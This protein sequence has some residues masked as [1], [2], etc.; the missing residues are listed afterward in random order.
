MSE[1]SD[2]HSVEQ[3]TKTPAMA[4]D[5]CIVHTCLQQPK[6][7]ISNVT[8]CTI[9]AKRENRRRKRE[10]LTEIPLIQSQQQTK[11]PRP[12]F[13][14]LIDESV[15]DVEQCCVRVRP[16]QPLC[17]QRVVFKI[18]NRYFCRL[19][20]H[21]HPEAKDA[22]VLKPKVEEPPPFEDLIDQKQTDPSRC[23]MREGRNRV[24]CYK[25]VTYKIRGKYFCG[26]HGTK[27]PHGQEAIT[28]PTT[29]HGRHAVVLNTM[30]E[31][32]SEITIVV[33][34]LESQ[35]DYLLGFKEFRDAIYTIVE[36][37]PNVP[38]PL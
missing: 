10:G 21:K 33:R 35:L 2:K 5:F 24:S 4:T 22:I 12:K 11:T 14:N 23:C 36:K 38:Q 28:M 18:K 20:G 19:H 32:L 15:V 3:D 1:R 31:R 34:K 7:T 27:H 17:T 25:Q 9:H 30:N 6:Y 8:Y 16:S 13:E 29:E 37:G 26:V